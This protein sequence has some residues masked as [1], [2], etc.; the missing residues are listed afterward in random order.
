M[1][2]ESALVL[3]FALSNKYLILEGISD[4][5]DKVSSL[6]HPGIVR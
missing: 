3:Y 4:K 1:L 6:E 2:E 5:F